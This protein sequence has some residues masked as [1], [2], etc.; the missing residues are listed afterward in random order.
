MQ[1]HASRVSRDLTLKRALPHTASA[2]P[3]VGLK[4]TLFIWSEKFNILVRNCL[5]R[6]GT[7]IDKLHFLMAVCFGLVWDSSQSHLKA[8]S[9]HGLQTA[10]KIPKMKFHIFGTTEGPCNILRLWPS[11]GLGWSVGVCWS[12]SDLNSAA[13][14]LRYKVLLG[15]KKSKT[16]STRQPGHA[17]SFEYR[18]CLSQKKLTIKQ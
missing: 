6:N 18:G 7:D 1:L 16:S 14:L 2:S 3:L 17:D 15:M 8:T 5:T 11:R 9:Q 13:G 4:N 10:S 12:T